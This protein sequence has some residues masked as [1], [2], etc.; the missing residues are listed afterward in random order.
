LF[1]DL[2][3]E[4]VVRA[5]EPL[6]GVAEVVPRTNL[7]VVQAALMLAATIDLSVEGGVRPIVRLAKLRN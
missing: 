4:R 6:P 1:A 7:A 3:G 2:P 5:P